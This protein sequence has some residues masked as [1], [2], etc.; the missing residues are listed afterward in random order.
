MTVALFFASNGYGKPGRITRW[1]GFVLLA[2]F[3]AYQ[4]LLYVQRGS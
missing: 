3:A 1:K 4:I 2:G